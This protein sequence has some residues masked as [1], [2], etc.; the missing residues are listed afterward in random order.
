MKTAHKALGILLVLVGLLLNPFLLS[1]LFSNDGNI[2]SIPIVSGIIS[3]EFLT[4]LY[5]IT[6]YQKSKETMMKMAVLLLS[7]VFALMVSVGLDRFYGAYLMPETSDILFPAFSVAKHETSEFDLTIRI[8]NLGFR[9]ENTSIQKKKK[10]VVLIGDSFTFGWGLQLED[11]WIQLISESFPEIEFLNLGQGGNHPGDHVRV[12][13]KALPLLKPDLVIV[14]ILQGN[15]LH[16]LMRVIE[17]KESGKSIRSAS[18]PVESSHERLKRYLRIV[19][20][21]FS[22]R[23]PSTTSIQERWKMDAQQLLAELNETERKKYRSLSTKLRTDLENGQLNPSLIYESIHHPT[24]FSE[25]ADTANQLCQKGIIRLHDHLQEMEILAAENGT[26]LLFL[27]LPNR[28]YGFPETQRAL[29]ELGF[30]VDGIDT[31]DANLPLK[32]AMVGLNS[33]LIF[34]QIPQQME[35]LFFHYDGHWNEHGNR[36]FAS[37]LISSLEQ[38][39][40]WKLFLTS[41][42]F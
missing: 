31:L 34:L 37:A 15:D 3:I 28:P 26:E 14:G 21:N 32:K 9:G 29:A 41:S 22:K 20:P 17:F 42:S 16:Q 1:F 8:N 19:F 2:S 13:K 33:E 39:S 38:N 35:P 6:I 11:T 18:Q 36:T 24:M 23:F 7:T 5:G 25:A 40:A 10:R 4:V 27:S 30:E 12:A